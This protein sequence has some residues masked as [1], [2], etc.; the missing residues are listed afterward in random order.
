MA[1][2]T[3]KEY[4]DFVLAEQIVQL[5]P[6]WRLPHNSTFASTYRATGNLAL[7]ESRLNNTKKSGLKKIHVEQK[8]FRTKCNNEFIWTA[9][10]TKDVPTAASSLDLSHE[11]EEREVPCVVIYLVEP[12]SMGSDQPELQ[13]LACLALLRCFQSVLTAVPDNIRSNINVQVGGSMFDDF[14]LSSSQNSR[15]YLFY[16]FDSI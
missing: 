4:A 15:K 11:E 16:Q 5:H 12:F 10:A 14:K 13:R 1:T 7:Q 6:D 9:D 2:F 8:F 3:N